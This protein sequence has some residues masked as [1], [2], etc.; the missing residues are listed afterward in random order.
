MTSLLSEFKGKNVFI[1]GHTGFKGSWLTAI[2]HNAGANILGF[3]LEPKSEPNLF[4]LLRLSEKVPSTF[5]DIRDKNRISTAIEDF[6]PEFIFH[7]AAQ[8]LVRPSYFDPIE[9]FTTN[10]VGSMNVLESV[11][12][13]DSIKS[14]IFVTSDK[15][16]ENKG[17]ALPYQE[18][19]KLGGH[20]PY[21]A[22]KAA[23]EILFHSYLDSYYRLNR[24]LGAASVRA[25]NVIGGGDR[26]LDRIVPDFIRAIEAKTP[27]ELRN[28]EAQRPW[29]HVLEPLNGYLKLAIELKNHPRDFSGSWNF[30]PNLDEVISVKELIG[31]FI[32]S[33]GTGSIT[34]VIQEEPM[35]EANYLRLDSRKSEEFLSWRPKWN[36][37]SCITKTIDWYRDVSLGA[38]PYAKTISQIEEYFS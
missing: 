24:Q 7:L 28:P 1:T 10:F 32:E 5:G 14:L 18:S 13:S 25:G 2:L 11:R 21:S 27:I 26:S 17:K 37:D 3:S 33:Y 23:A 16:Y 30:G 8:A 29:Q 31:K 38:D 35:H 19:D 15:C 4:K 20:D 36:I 22:S 12:H 9:T 6:Q 34:Q